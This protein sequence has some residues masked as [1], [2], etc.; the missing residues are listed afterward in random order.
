MKI[1]ILLVFYF[2]LGA[3][4][5]WIFARKK[6][7]AKAKELWTKYAVYVF[8]VF[9]IISVL[10]LDK[11]YFTLISLA[12][13]IVGLIEIYICTVENQ[14]LKIKSVFYYL[15]IS[16]L[17]ISGTFSFDNK[18]LQYSY[19]IIL[20]FD[21]FSQI[22]GQLIGGQ[23]LIPSISP[24]KTVAGLV[25]GLITA[26]ITCIFIGWDIYNTLI[27]IVFGFV[28]DIL[29]SYLKRKSN[30][31]DFSQLIPGHGGFLDR[32]DSYIMAIAGLNIFAHLF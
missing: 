19:L 17:F 13:S 28:G 4:G 6:E 26:I 14:S 10:Q 29:A 21:G 15:L 27:I 7:P 5:M 11:I 18:T 9:S 32:F 23:K 31:K 30:V 24:N 3:I 2:V 25:G 22:I 8:I 12:I 1:Y 20:T 16:V